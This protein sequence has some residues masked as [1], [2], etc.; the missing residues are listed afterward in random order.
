MK[1]IRMMS[2]CGATCEVQIRIIR[3]RSSMGVVAM[4]ESNRIE[5]NRIESNRIESRAA[6]AFASLV[7]ARG[8]VQ[9]RLEFPQRL[10]VRRFQTHA[11]MT[12]RVPSIERLDGVL[13]TA[14]F[15][16]HEV[17]DG[18]AR[19]ARLPAHAIHQDAS[20]HASFVGASR[21]RV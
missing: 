7:G 11:R 1:C 21:A 16:V 10:G 17:G 3:A 15:A 12:S 14:S 8:G 20:R 18:D 6:R 13:H 19:R 5:S 2:V 4:R 9:L